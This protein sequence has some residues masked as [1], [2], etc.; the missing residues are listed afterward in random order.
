MRSNHSRDTLMSFSDHSAQRCFKSNAPI[1]WPEHV[2]NF[3]SQSKIFTA[4]VVMAEKLDLISKCIRTF[5]DFPTKGI[6]F[7]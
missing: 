1:G 6:P 4:R 5:P 3:P 7:K 2:D